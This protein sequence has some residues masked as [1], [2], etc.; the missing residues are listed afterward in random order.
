MPAAQGKASAAGRP[1]A[2]SR[3]VWWA[4]RDPAH[5]YAVLTSAL[6][7]I[8]TIWIFCL[9]CMICADIVARSFFNAPIYGVTEVVGASIVRRITNFE[10]SPHA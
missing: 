8:G 9:M 6:N 3:N 10:L 2:W 7:S 4:G 1:S 5:L